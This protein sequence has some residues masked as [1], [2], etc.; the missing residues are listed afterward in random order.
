M[1]TINLLPRDQGPITQDYLR[2]IGYGFLFLLI[3]GSVILTAGLWYDTKLTIE[4]IELK[5]AE[6]SSVKGSINDANR[7]QQALATIIDRKTTTDKLNSNSIEYEAILTDIASATPQNVKLTSLTIKTGEP[8]HLI[9]QAA[10]Q[11]DIAQFLDNLKTSKNLIGVSL[12]Q[13][14]TQTG[15]INFVINAQQSKNPIKK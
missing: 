10:Q 2:E 14:S 6:K 8:I 1:R 11:S 9:G 5:Q 7:F 3:V 13:T 12:S 4:N 15:G